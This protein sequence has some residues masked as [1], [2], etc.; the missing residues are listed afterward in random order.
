MLATALKHPVKYTLS[1]SSYTVNW[2]I[3]T[4][5]QIYIIHAFISLTCSP[6]QES[7]V[8]L[9]I[10]TSQCKYT[11]SALHLHL[12]IWNLNRLVGDSP[13]EI[14]SIVESFGLTHLKSI[15]ISVMKHEKSKI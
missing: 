8:L 7:L 2:K 12:N 6:V 3:A 5:N 10:S 4:H 9:Q 1:R 11:S 15:L 14:I 13:L